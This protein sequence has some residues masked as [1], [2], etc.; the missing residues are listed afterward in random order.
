MSV[1]IDEPSN[2]PTLPAE[3][4]DTLVRLEIASR[5]GKGVRLTSQE[6]R[7]FIHMYRVL[8][9]HFWTNWIPEEWY[10]E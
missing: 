9:G 5:Q 4:E 7:Y 1:M 2:P 6:A 8:S 10:D 3:F